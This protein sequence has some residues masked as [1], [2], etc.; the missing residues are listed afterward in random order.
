MFENF[1][2]FIRHGRQAGVNP[3]HPDEAHHVMLDDEFQ[4]QTDSIAGGIYTGTD[5]TQNINST[6]TERHSPA[7]VR[8]HVNGHI[9]H[10]DFSKVARDLV[11]RET[12]LEEETKAKS[13]RESMQRYKIMDKLGEGAFSK[14]YKGLNIETG[15]HVAVKVI[16][17]SQLDEKQRASVLKEVTLM[18]QLD[19]P[20]IVKFLDFIENDQC[21]YIV[22]ELVDGGE[23]F[24]QIVKYTYFSEDL[25][26][27]VIIQVAEALLYLHESV[28]IVHRDLKPENIFFN[29]ILLKPSRNRI[30]RLSDDPNTKLDEGEFRMNYGGGGIGLV[31]IGDFGLSKQIFADNSLKTPCGTIGYTAPEI[32]KDMKYSKEV[33][34]WALGCILYIL[35][36]GFP[37]FFNDSIDELTQKVAKGE[38]E[39]LSP[40]WDEI[41]DGAKHCA[42][43]LLTV[44]PRERY[45]ITQFMNDPWILEFLHRSESYRDPAE[46]RQS[47]LSL[48]QSGVN[49]Q[50]VPLDI[51][52][53]AVGQYAEIAPVGGDY[54][55]STAATLPR[56]E[57]MAGNKDAEMSDY[58]THNGDPALRRLKQDADMFSPAVIAMREAMDITTVAHRLHEEA[59][60]EEARKHVRVRNNRALSSLAE[61]TEYTQSSIS[62]NETS[63][64][65]V[66]GVPCGTDAPLEMKP[67]E[68]KLDDS[69]ILRRR[70]DRV[71]AAQ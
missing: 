9:H 32:V 57:S 63:H 33:D 31:K 59:F 60:E 43:K 8:T 40:W 64:S 58:R 24:N 35:L 56:Y 23:L 67:F 15:E 7:P 54:S 4:R 70:R 5:N 66:A 47:A 28:G 27:H 44:N 46:R 20:N 3:Q 18:R 49:S 29:P 34:M 61:E 1:R 52:D 41:S 14:V 37:P 2:N 36:C 45:S 65:V 19:H 12:E 48:R 69:S 38:Y 10:E 13:R 53:A 42:S 62:S 21:F 25:A 11:K 50:S 22:Q 30:L 68:L 39:F 17:K 16:M 55:W 26:R 6:A 71:L 51:P